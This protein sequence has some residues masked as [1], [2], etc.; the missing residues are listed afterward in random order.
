[1]ARPIKTNRGK[2]PP[3]TRK[4]TDAL[5]D[6]DRRGP[7]HSAYKTAR[8]QRLRA[9]VLRDRPLCQ[10][11]RAAGRITPATVVHHEDETSEGHPVLCDPDRLTPLCRPCH[12]RRHGGLWGRNPGR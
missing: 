10:D 5:Y 11:C 1:M 8:W 9:L 6:R 7:E 4:A 3:T 12:R 2:L